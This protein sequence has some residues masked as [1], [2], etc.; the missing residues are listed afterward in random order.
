ML[1]LIY[2]IY[3]LPIPTS[4]LFGIGEFNCSLLENQYL[5]LE[6]WVITVISPFR[7][8]IVIWL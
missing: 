6:I 5:H 1:V 8:E 3:F 4:C 2:S 7:K